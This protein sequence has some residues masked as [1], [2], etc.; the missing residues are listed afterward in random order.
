MRLVQTFDL[1]FLT[2]CEWASIYETLFEICAILTALLETDV[3]SQSRWTWQILTERFPTLRRWAR[4]G[5]HFCTWLRWWH[6]AGSEGMSYVQ[7]RLRAV[8]PRWRPLER[9]NTLW[10]R[11]TAPTTTTTTTLLLDEGELIAA[12]IQTRD[13]PGWTSWGC[14][15]EYMWTVWSAGCE[16]E[17][18]SRSCSKHWLRT[19]SDIC[20]IPQNLNQG[21]HQPEFPITPNTQ[22]QAGICC[23]FNLNGAISG[24]MIISLIVCFS[25]AWHGGLCWFM[26]PFLQHVHQHKTLQATKE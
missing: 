21:L 17:T 1:F 25:F 10:H 26:E 14:C 23:S 7:E 8:A 24:L 15:A 18:V 6:S 4:S 9:R 20:L 19:T 12:M 5:G 3:L 13:S 2:L 22:I 16:E 11:P